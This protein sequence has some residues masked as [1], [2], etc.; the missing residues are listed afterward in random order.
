MMKPSL[1]EELERELGAAP[2]RPTAVVVAAAPD[3]EPLPSDGDGQA[4]R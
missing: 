1:Q 4:R 2:A 3:H